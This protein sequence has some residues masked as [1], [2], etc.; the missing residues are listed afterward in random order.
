[1][2]AIFSFGRIWVARPWDVC[3][4]FR[5]GRILGLHFQQG[6]W[7]CYDLRCFLDIEMIW[8]F[9]L[10]NIVA[11]T[12]HGLLTL[13]T[14]ENRRF[15][16]NRITNFVP[17]VDPRQRVGLIVPCKGVESGLIDN[18]ACFLNQDYPFYRVTFVVESVDDPAYHVVQ[19]LVSSVQP[20]KAHVV[21]AGQGIGSGQKIHNLRAAIAA[22]PEEV[23]VYV[24]ADSDIRPDADWL[25]AIVSCLFKRNRGAAT[26]Y[27][28]FV[29]SRNTLANLLLYSFNSATAALYGP[30]GHF[31]VW[32]GSWAIRRGDF[33]RIAVADAWQGTLSDDLVA[34]RAL[35]L[36]KLKVAFEPRA[37]VASH[38]DTDVFALGEFVRRQFLIGRRYATR[39][40]LLSW[41]ALTLS[42]IAFWGSA[43]LAIWHLS[44]GRSAAWLLL[45]NTA[46]LY[47]ATVARAWL[48]QDMTRIYLPQQHEQLSVA[49]RFDIWLS[50]FA[51]ILLWGGFVMSCVGNEI[52]WRGIGYFIAPGGRIQ[53]LG[54]RAARPV[55]PPCEPASD[56]PHREAA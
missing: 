40:W 32:G 5:L 44:S 42:L 29:P 49:R 36:S 18:L 14:W 17:G 21:I 11:W 53:L 12:Y 2:M 39:M 51:G 4:P 15:A 28:W 48:R 1:M 7:R 16:L 52:V 6:C 43:A 19:Q 24:F 34:S 3:R 22:Q 38:I 20:S 56:V 46:G 30:G 33:E 47:L 55:D 10:L 23:N 26:G 54:R 13:A 9:T 27:R 50:P 37:M 31:L 25:R 45:A 8:V 41:S 35:R